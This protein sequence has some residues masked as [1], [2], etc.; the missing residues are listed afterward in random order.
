MK[1]QFI[2]NKKA[3]WYKPYFSDLLK[4]LT[5]N[6][7]I[8]K[9]KNWTK[10]NLYKKYDI[11]HF[12]LSNSTRSVLLTVPFFKSKRKI[13]TI[14]DI[15]PRTRIIPTF[16]IRIMYRYLNFLTDK[17]IVHSEFA[18]EM[19][20]KTAPS[21]SDGKIIVIPHGCKIQDKYKIEYLRK[22]YS[23]PQKNIILLMAGVIKK[24]KG[25]LEVIDA[26]KELNL[27]NINLLITGKT[28]D[29]ESEI[30]LDNLRKKNIR[31]L[32]FLKDE[33]FYDY[34]Q[35]SDAFISYRLDSVG[36]SSGPVLLAIGAGKPVIYSNM[37]SFPEVVQNGGLECSSKKELKENIIKFCKDESIRKKLEE[38]IRQI[39]KEYSWETVAK[40]HMELYEQL[41]KEKIK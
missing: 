24:S 28:A 17:L 13:L 14:H 38:N 3:L 20:L 19:L 25:Q 5:S 40:K 10:I 8:V 32:G 12:H 41:I 22:K 18:K 37:G 4:E 30:K 39:R 9:L 36:E 7:N 35:L 31:Y 26:F 1:I 15:I 29:K 6:S 34:I 21:L 16:C 27:K 11:S 23:I 33:E 2:I